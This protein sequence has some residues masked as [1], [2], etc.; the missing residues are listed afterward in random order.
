M[1]RKRRND[2]GLP[3]RCRTKSYVE[4]PSESER[5][6]EE[7][8]EIEAQTERVHETSLHMR[9]ELDKTINRAKTA[10]EDTA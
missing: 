8:A 9:Q 4:V 7:L 1:A 10:D 6:L 2:D 3:P 5:L